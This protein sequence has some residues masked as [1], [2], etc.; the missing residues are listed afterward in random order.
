[1]AIWAREVTPNSKDLYIIFDGS[2][3]VIDCEYC[4]CGGWYVHLIYSNLKNDYLPGKDCYM[5]LGSAVKASVVYNSSFDG[6][7]KYKKDCNDVYFYNCSYAAGPYPSSALATSAA[8]S[9]TQKN[10]SISSC[11]YVSTTKFYIAGNAKNILSQGSNAHEYVTCKELTFSVTEL[12]C[13]QTS[14]VKISTK[15][16]YEMADVYGYWGPYTT[17][18]T[19]NTELEKIRSNQT[20]VCSIT[21]PTYKV[22]NVK[23]YKSPSCQGGISDLQL[24]K[25]YLR[26]FYTTEEQTK[27]DDFALALGYE[28]RTLAAEFCSAEEAQ[29]YMCA[30]NPD[31]YTDPPFC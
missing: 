31:D 20:D 6:G 27:C 23:A 25:P 9:Y 29:A 13:S 24:G 22:Y 12:F 15:C 28:G 3:T 21:L 1:M 2:N 11:F 4:P 19:A 7:C 8:A 17:A 16:G 10:T 26:V 14:S 5:P 18:Y 30:L